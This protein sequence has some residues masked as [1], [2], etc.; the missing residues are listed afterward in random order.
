MEKVARGNPLQIL[1]AGD[2]LEDEDED[3]GDAE[4][5]DDH[6]PQTAP[7]AAAGETTRRRVLIQPRGK[8][9]L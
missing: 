2:N 6:D 9:L 7:A 8:I 4:A 3:I 1:T 5:I